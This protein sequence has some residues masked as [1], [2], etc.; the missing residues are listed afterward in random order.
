MTRDPDVPVEELWQRFH[1]L[2]NMTSREL[3][4]WLGTSEELAPDPAQRAPALGVAVLGILRKRRT[5]LTGDDRDIMWQVISVVEDETAG[6][7]TAELLSDERRR[8][9]L[10]NVGHDPIKA[11]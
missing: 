7:S 2:V 1:E 8:Y 5:D 3:T 10:L 6:R 11:G 4:D 9:R